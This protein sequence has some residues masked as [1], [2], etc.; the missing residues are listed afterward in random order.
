MREN[1]PLGST[2][3]IPINNALIP[4]RKAVSI[5][6]NAVEHEPSD[7]VPLNDGLLKAL[8]RFSIILQKT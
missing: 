6:K 8:Y 1:I 5:V 3:L 2:L 4:S 7:W